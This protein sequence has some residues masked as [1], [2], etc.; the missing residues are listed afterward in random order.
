MAARGRQQLYV[1][2]GAS[3]QRQRDR[4][5]LLKPVA[6]GDRDEEM[7]NGDGGRA[8]GA[9]GVRS[10]RGRRAVGAGREQDV[11]RVALRRTGCHRAGQLSDDR[12]E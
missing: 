7:L 6:N 1:V 12:V 3:C 4:D 11:R 8:S 10:R 9:A 2:S 5:Q